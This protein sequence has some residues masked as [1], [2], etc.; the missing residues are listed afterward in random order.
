MEMKHRAAMVALI[1]ITLV[2]FLAAVRA[3][4]GTYQTGVFC[5]VYGYGTWIRVDT[6]TSW[7]EIMNITLP[8]IPVSAYYHVS[9]DGYAALNYKPSLKIAISV[10]SIPTGSDDGT[11]RRFYEYPEVISATTGIHTERVYH[12]AP[13]SHTFHF[14]GTLHVMPTSAH[15]NINYMSM[16]VVVFS[17]GALSE[18]LGTMDGNEHGLQE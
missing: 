11:T 17:D 14:I 16:T 15:A 9:C 8:N 10:N 12:L 1:G 13:G 2:S 5:K 4:T 7:V 3:G 6:K 18:S